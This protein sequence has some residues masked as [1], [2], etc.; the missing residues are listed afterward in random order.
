[1][2]FRLVTC[3]VMH[4]SRAR[5]ALIEFVT[6]MYTERAVRCVY[7]S[8]S[9]DDTHFWRA[10]ARPSQA[11]RRALRFGRHP[12]SGHAMGSSTLHRMAKEW[13]I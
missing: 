10:S 13:A 4:I 1:M 5:F 7:L 2:L 8:T 6:S 3:A 12:C 11:R 9:V